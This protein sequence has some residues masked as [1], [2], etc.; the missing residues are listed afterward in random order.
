MV[1]EIYKALFCDSKDGKFSHSKAGVMVASVAFTLKMLGLLP[2]APDDW[3]LWATFMGT[4]GG[5]AA[6]LKAV[7][8]KAEKE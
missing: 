2:D 1:T 7:R 4:V 3:V 8:I 6:L 5:Y